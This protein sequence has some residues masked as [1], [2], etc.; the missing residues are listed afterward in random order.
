M[1]K[2]K[3]PSKAQLAGDVC[4]DLRRLTEKEFDAL[5]SDCHSREMGEWAV[6]GLHRAL[7]TI[8]HLKAKESECQTK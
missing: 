5:H 4:G 1:T 7:V 6:R 8:Q 3:K 2:T